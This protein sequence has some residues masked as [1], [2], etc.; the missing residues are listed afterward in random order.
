MDNNPTDYD[1]LRSQKRRHQLSREKYFVVGCVKKP[2]ICKKNLFGTRPKQIPPYGA[3]IDKNDP[4]SINQASDSD[5]D[6]D[7]ENVQ[8]EYNGQDLV[9]MS[10]DDL[11]KLIP[12]TNTYNIYPGVSYVFDITG[13]LLLP[14]QPRHQDDNIDKTL[15]VINKYNKDNA[16]RIRALK[17]YI[18]ACPRVN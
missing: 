4:D 1:P 8:S 14:P 16:E 11:R 12:H 6:D 15:E 7:Q 18:I 5:D 3:I 17:Q 2:L 10:E 9:D 13:R